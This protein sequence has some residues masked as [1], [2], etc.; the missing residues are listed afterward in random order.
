MPDRNEPHDRLEREINEIL[1]NIERFPSPDQR[2]Q[3]A[4]KRAVTDFLDAIAIR[5]QALARWISRVGVSQLMLLS[6][7][8]ILGSFFFREIAPI[9]WPWLMYAGVVLFLTCFAIMMFGGT[10]GP[11]PSTPPQ[12]WR[13]RP[14]QNSQTNLAQSFRRW[15]NRRRR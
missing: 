15:W 7:V 1:S 6:F 8:L 9:S 3:R 11:G 2:R 12:Y 13:G 14:V 4:R 10:R 5:Q